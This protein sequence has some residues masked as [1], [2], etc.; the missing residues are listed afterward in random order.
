MI[1]SRDASG[2]DVTAFMAAFR[3]DFPEVPVVL[4]PTTYNHLTE[5]ELH[6]RGASVIIHANHLLRASYLA[7]RD[8]ADSILE[9][10]RSME[11]DSLCLPIR[12]VLTLIPEE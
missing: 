3:A 2:D 1:H 8:V 7:M 9:H 11:A 12:D 4:V 5:E 6:G 10:G